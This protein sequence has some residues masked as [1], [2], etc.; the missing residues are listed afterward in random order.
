MLA[1]IGSFHLAIPPVLPIRRSPE[2]SF[3]GKSEAI[4][5]S[6]ITVSEVSPNDIRSEARMYWNNRRWLEGIKLE[7]M[8]GMET[9]ILGVMD[10]Q[11]DFFRLL[12]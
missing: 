8:K 7:D 5:M 11:E 10:I 1:E 12:G 6:N 2:R 4:A 9:R 3:D